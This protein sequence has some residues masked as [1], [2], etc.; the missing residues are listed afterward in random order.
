MDIYYENELVKLV[1]ADNLEYLRTIAD[2]SIQLIYIDPQYFSQRDYIEF[3][4]IWK[5]MHEYLA[6]IEIRIKEIYRILKPNGCFYLHCDQHANAYLRVL[7]DQIFGY[8]HFIQE[9]IWNKMPTVS[10]FKLQTINKFITVNDTILFY[11]KSNNYLFNPIFIYYTTEQL[12]KIYKQKDKKGIYKITKTNK[13]VYL[14]NDDG[15]PLTNIWNDI[16][17]SSYSTFIYNE[18]CG[19]P[20]QKPLGIAQRIIQASSNEGDLVLDAF[21]GSGTT[22]IASIQLKRKAI[23]IDNN[24]N[25]LKKTKE[26][27]LSINSIEKSS[28]LNNVKRK[29]QLDLSFY[30]NK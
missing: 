18:Y 12:N 23:G 29:I 13:K 28:N 25:A 11:A 3:S 9:I 10:G 4:D 20:T 27:L 30:D 1:H 8:E 15:I 26:R 5:N 22:I 19:Y 2:N 24:L 17:S 7:C 6:Y 14:E 16:W 21:C